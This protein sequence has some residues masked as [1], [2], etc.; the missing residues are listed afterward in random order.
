TGS[1]TFG[2]PTWASGSATVKLS[3]TATSYT[4]QY[5]INSGSWNNLSSAASG[6]TGTNGNVGGLKHNDTLYARLT[7]GAQY[8]DETSTKITDTTA[9]SVVVTVTGK[10]TSKLTV[11]ATATDGQSGM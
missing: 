3:T 1:I 7:N 4:I 6:N 11:K 9:P 8:G 10:D 2:A 5:R